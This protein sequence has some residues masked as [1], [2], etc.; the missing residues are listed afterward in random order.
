M[1]TAICKDLN[2]NFTPVFCKL[3]ENWHGATSLC[4]TREQLERDHPDLTFVAWVTDLDDREA[5]ECHFLSPNVQSV[6]V[7]IEVD[8]AF[9]QIRLNRDLTTDFIPCE[10]VG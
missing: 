1:K 7:W 4:K 5:L 3:W 9:T 2:G 8:S 10:L 6:I